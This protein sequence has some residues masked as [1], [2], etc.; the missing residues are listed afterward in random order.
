L[1]R[2]IS[3][4]SKPGDLVL[5]FF[6]GSGTTGDAAMQLSRR[7]ILVDNNPEAINVMKKRFNQYEGIEYVDLDQA[8]KNDN[9]SH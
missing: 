1:K 9:P 8:N 7:F 5:D 4:S 3:A 6:A 2:I